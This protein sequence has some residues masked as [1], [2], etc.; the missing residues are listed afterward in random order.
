MVVALLNDFG[1]QKQTTFHSGGALLVGLAL[2]GLAG[3]VGAQAQLNVSPMHGIDGV[4]HWNNAGGVN[5]T[6][7][8]NDLEKVI[9]FVEHTGLLVG[10]KL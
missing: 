5:R 4:S 7:L 3:H 8:F 1:N 10:V 6:D 2:V 9:D